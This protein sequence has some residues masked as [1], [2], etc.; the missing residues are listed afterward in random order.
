MW[1]TEPENASST[2]G[3]G[4][5]L[6]G[7]TAIR[8]E[9]KTENPGIWMH[10]RVGFPDDPTEN[11]IDTTVI[12]YA[13]WTNYTLP[14]NSSL[15]ISD[16]SGG[17]NID[18]TKWGIF[19][20]PSC[21]VYL[22]DIQFILPRPDSLRFIKS[23]ITDC[24][25]SDKYWAWNQAYTS[26][27]ALAMLAYLSNPDHE[28]IRR[29]R[30]LG[31][32]FRF[33]QEHDRYY[34]DGRLRNAYRAG[35][36][37]QSVDT[38]VRLP[39]WYDFD[40]L[41][42]YEDNYQVSSYTGPLAWVMIA[43]LT[44][45]SLTMENRYLDAALNLGEWIWNTCYDASG[46]PGYTGGFFGNDTHTVPVLWKSTEHNI[47]VYVAFK[48][49]YYATGEIAWNQRA[50]I[51]G[52]FIASLWDPVTGHFYT[53]TTETGSISYFSPLDP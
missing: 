27:N 21:I 36:L 29:A 19:P 13:T 15:N 16:I 12:L 4:Y 25:P 5:N 34:S 40:S 1:W 3:P 20:Y 6:T 43:W 17:F 47:D 46:I 7:A 11:V 37:V 9:A 33:A 14:I 22:D 52:N 53:G 50:E 28:N 2:S 32:A 42:W 31:D 39:G 23:Y 44:Y 38:F 35:D 10:V 49:L 26:D 45:D 41:T 51:A 24:T 48:R 30:I 8:F 18:F